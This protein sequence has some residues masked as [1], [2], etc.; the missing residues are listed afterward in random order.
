M[1]RDAKNAVRQEA[2]DRLRKLIQPGD[3]VYTTVRH[4]SRSGMSRVIDAHLIKNNEPIWIGRLVAKAIE[5][6]YNDDK[7]GV[8]MYGGGMDMTFELVYQLGSVLWPKGFG[9]IGEECRSNDHSNGDRD[10]TPHGTPTGCQSKV[11]YC[12]DDSAGYSGNPC[13]SCGCHPAE[14]WHLDGGYAL[15]RESL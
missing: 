15:R 1:T 4:V 2:I 7:Q 5:S 14:H 3:K 10:Y 8:V 6:R 13:S 9:C 11:C 12:H